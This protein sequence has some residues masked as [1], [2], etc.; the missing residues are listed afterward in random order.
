MSNLFTY[1]M[2]F[3]DTDASNQDTDAEDA[4]TAQ[5]LASAGDDAITLQLD[6][7]ERADFDATLNAIRAARI[8]AEIDEAWRQHDREEG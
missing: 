1:L 4:R 2:S 3:D 8:A 5:L 7:A 6:M